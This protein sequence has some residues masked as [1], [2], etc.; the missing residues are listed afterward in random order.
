MF[1]IIQINNFFHL[2]PDLL[3]FAPED[4]EKLESDH[5]EP[6][7]PKY[8]EFDFDVVNVDMWHEV[9]DDDQ[10]DNVLMYVVDVMVVMDIMVVVLTVLSVFVA[11][12][13]VDF[14]KALVVDVQWM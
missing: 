1:D 6:D 10:I 7:N 9:M 5:H 14:V 11:V 8:H 3:F 12:F 13:G 4:H 2:S